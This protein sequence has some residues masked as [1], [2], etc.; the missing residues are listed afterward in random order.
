MISKNPGKQ[1]KALYQANMHTRHKFVAAHLSRQL[2]KQFGKRSLPV[3]KGDEVKVMR[4]K[5][6]GVTGKVSDVDMK[7]LTV[8]IEG[9]KRKKVSGQEVPV[10]LKPSKLLIINPVLDDKHRK[11][12]IERAINKKV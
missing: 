5:Y 11:A 7:K 4:G 2:I 3:R 6:S 12:V 9:I 1:R 8:F 10:P